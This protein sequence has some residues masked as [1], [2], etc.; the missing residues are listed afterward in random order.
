MSDL[1]AG[2]VVR[3]GRSS[4]GSSLV[5]V[6]IIDRVIIRHQ[7]TTHDLAWQGANDIIVLQ[8]QLRDLGTRAGDAEPETGV[9]T[10]HP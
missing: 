2:P 4:E 6:I 10:V 3:G 1:S 9:G 8:V 7:V 5:I